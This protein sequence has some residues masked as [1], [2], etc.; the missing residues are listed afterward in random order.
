MPTWAALRYARNPFNER[1]LQKYYK[2]LSGL[3]VSSYSDPSQIGIGR[4]DERSRARDDER[5]E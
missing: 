1:G 3:L 4:K 5:N 2:E